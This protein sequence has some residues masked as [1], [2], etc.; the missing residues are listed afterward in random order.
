MLSVL[1]SS[2]DIAR[3]EEANQITKITLKIGE[4]SGVVVDSLRFAFESVRLNTIAEHAELEI[5]LIPFQGECLHCGAIFRAENFLI[6][7]QCG[8]IGKLISGQEL[9]IQSIEID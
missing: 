1:E 2:L 5:D 7:G 3:K 8:N 9:Q 4:K 6:C